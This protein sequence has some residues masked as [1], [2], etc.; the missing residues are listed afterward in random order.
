M[1]TFFFVR[2][3]R[4]HEKIRFADIHFLEAR[5]NY[6]KIQTT[7]RTY[8]VPIPLK[9]IEAILPAGDFCRIHRAFLVSLDKLTAFDLK[10]AYLPNHT[11]PI[12]DKYCHALSLQVT[13]LNPPAHAKQPARPGHLLV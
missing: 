13:F 6:C 7:E 3:G 12:G 2:V 4:R 10:R 1:P 11:L 9:T 5:G 8:M